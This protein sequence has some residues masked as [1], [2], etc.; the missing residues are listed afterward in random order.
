MS[1][2]YNVVPVICTFRTFNFKFPSNLSDSHLD[3]RL[4]DYNNYLQTIEEDPTMF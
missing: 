2:N 4:H 1:M 3:K